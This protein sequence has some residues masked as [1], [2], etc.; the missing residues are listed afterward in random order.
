MTV[1]IYQTLSGRWT[2]LNA[3]RSYV[4]KGFAIRAAIKL[5]YQYEV[6]E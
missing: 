1:K 2:W 4:S 5:E 3:G 6:I